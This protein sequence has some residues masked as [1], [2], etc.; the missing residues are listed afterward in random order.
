MAGYTVNFSLLS[1]YRGISADRHVS[2]SI[3]YAV[4]R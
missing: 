2:H 4:S 3:L 1:Q